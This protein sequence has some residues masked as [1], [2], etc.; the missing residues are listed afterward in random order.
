MTKSEILRRAAKK[1]GLKLIEVKLA[2]F[3]A[4]HW[5]PKV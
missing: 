4:K 5:R 1:L 3:N 2:K